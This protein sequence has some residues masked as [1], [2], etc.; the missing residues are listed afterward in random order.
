MINGFSA[1]VS[2]VL[3]AGELAEP[4]YNTVRMPR[5]RSVYVLP[6]AEGKKGI[7]IYISGRCGDPLAGVKSFGNEAAS[8]ATMIALQGD[9]VCKFPVGRHRW[10][11]DLA[12]MQRR[13]EEAI[14]AVSVTMPHLD[15]NDV[16]IIGYSEGALRVVQLV[17][18]FP[19]RYRRVVL[20]G[21]PVIPTVSMMGRAKAIAAV[22]GE[23]DKQDHVHPGLATL[24]EN[25]I[26]AKFFSLPEVGHG[27]YG[28]WGHESF[29]QAFTWIFETVPDQ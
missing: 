14:A 3:A 19:D 16:T 2:L 7:M 24:V 20:G 11:G 21:P 8:H 26:P 29:G 18:R 15:P 4:K 6:S 5:D 17:E 25:G 23:L 13:I 12:V 28:N 22:V 27:K 9:V 10:S 1:L